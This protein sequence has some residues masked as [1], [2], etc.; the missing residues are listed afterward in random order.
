MII[1]LCVGTIFK[2]LQY[3]NCDVYKPIKIS[4]ASDEVRV[5]NTKSFNLVMK[6]VLG[7]RFLGCLQDGG[8]CCGQHFLDL[9]ISVLAAPTIFQSVGKILLR[10]S[11]E[12]EGKLAYL[13]MGLS[14]ERSMANSLQAFVVSTLAN[15]TN[16]SSAVIYPDV[17]DITLVFKKMRKAIYMN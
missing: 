15:F 4:L 9:G 7:C 17:L 5:C 3:L 12:E 8:R 6:P 14:S 1:W 16:L 2:T 13:S 10:S 11:V